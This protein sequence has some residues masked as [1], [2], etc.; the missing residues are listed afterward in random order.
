MR[1]PAVAPTTVLP[2]AARRGGRDGRASRGS[3]ARCNALVREQA[4]ARGTVAL[5]EAAR[6]AARPAGPTLR[7]DPEVRRLDSA[8]HLQNRCYTR[9]V[10]ARST[11]KPTERPR[12][13]LPG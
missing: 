2:Q 6:M 11:P 3:V 7:G 13:L 4:R 10:Y 9:S 8:R 12:R 1:C 5:N